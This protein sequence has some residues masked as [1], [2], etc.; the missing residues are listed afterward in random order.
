MTSLAQATIISHLDSC[1]SLLTAA[2]SAPLQFILHLGCHGWSFRKLNQDTS[3]FWLK[4]SLGFPLRLENPTFLPLLT[5]LCIIWL[6]PPS[7]TL[8]VP[9]RLH[10][11]CH[12]ALFIFWAYQ[13]HFCFVTECTG[14]SF[15]LHC[16]SLGFTWLPPSVI[17]DLSLMGSLPLPL[18]P[19]NLLC[20]FFPLPGLSLNYL[21]YI[22]QV[23]LPIC[24]LLSSHQLPPLLLPLH[25][26]Y[27][28]YQDRDL[29]CRIHCHIP[30][31]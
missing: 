15:N 9:S 13:A 17:P 12:V 29:T 19:E 18:S 31:T 8:C 20:P 14:C 22:Y 2:T 23:M 25:I 30:S 24:L 11:L 4:P 5:K 1:T 28:L 3:L 7:L 6:L 26:E 27:K 16:A 10:Q 21:Y